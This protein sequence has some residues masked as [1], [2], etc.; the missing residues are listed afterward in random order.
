MPPAEVPF[1]VAGRE[2]SRRILCATDAAA[3]RAGL[4]VG[5]PVAQAQALLPNLVLLE[6][7]PERDGEALAALAVRVLRRHSPIVALD[8]PDGLWIDATGCDHLFG[9][10]EAMLADLRRCLNGEG[11][12]C[13]VALAGTTGAAHALARFGG[14]GLVVVPQ[15]G[16]GAAVGALPLAALRLSDEVVAGLARLGFETIGQLA[17]VPRAPLVRRFG[18]EVVRRLDQV[19]GAAAEP[20]D[21]IEPPDMPRVRL[22]F[23]EPIGSP[24]HLARAIAELAGMLCQRLA[25]QGLGARRLDLAFTRVDGRVETV[26]AGT[27]APNRQ[28]HHLVRLLVERLSTVDPG[29]GVEAM[30]LAAPLAEPLDT[31][32]IAAGF[33]DAAAGDIALLVDTLANRLGAHR[34]YRAA[35]VESDVPERA[36]RAVAPLAPAL[37]RGWPAELPRPVRLLDPPEEV[38]T[39]A[40]LPDHPPTHFV[41]RGTRHHVTR[42]DGPERLFGEW[43]RR[44]AEWAAVRDYFAV[45]DETGARFWL[46]RAGDGSDP[47]TGSH[48]WFLQGL[49]A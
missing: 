38:Q 5:M 32:Q 48:R 21:P 42:A 49:F 13:R 46:F 8:P 11:F 22:G 31:R 41:W 12:A 27:A 25:E 28:P 40:L 36:V 35:P 16:E 19:S 23:V 17:A 30:T 43:W 39:L 4:H 1:A 7:E 45:E 29:F 18:M 6:A 24:E 34:L 44:D 15:R 37:G 2:G 20:L 33:A 10:E 47:A 3:R 9:G 26:R 14:K